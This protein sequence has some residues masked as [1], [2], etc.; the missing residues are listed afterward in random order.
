MS[1]TPEPHAQAPDPNPADALVADVLTVLAG[2]GAVRHVLQR[3]A[4]AVV[5][6]LD[7]AFARIW[8]LNQAEQVLELEASAGMYTHLDGQHSRIPVGA[9]KIGRIAEARRPHLTNDVLTDPE[10]SDPDWARR[11]G[12]VAFAGY[13]LLSGTRLLGVVAVLARHPLLS[14]SLEALAAASE[15]MAAVVERLRTQERLRAE[16]R[17]LT[18]LQR[19]G[20]AL[21]SAQ[22]DLHGVVQTVTDAATELSGAEFGAFFYN[23]MAANGE[24]YMLYTLSGA[25][26]DAFA[27]FGLPRNTPLFEPTFRGLRTLCLDDVGAD[28]RY[29][30]VP[31]HHGMPPGHLPVRSYLAV[32]VKGRDGTVLGGLFFGHAQPGVFTELSQ[33]AVEAIAGNAA[34]AIENARLY[35]R[36]HNVAVTLQRSL[37]PDRLPELDD[38]ALSAHYLPAAGEFEVGGDWYDAMVLPD[39]RLA[40]SVGDVMGHDLRAAAAMG[41]VR[42]ALRAYILEGWEPFG[43]GVLP[44]P[45]HERGG[46]GRVHHPRLRR[47]GSSAPL[48]SARAGRPP[49]ARAPPARRHRSAGRR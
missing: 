37:L 6:R 3:C 26:P 47:G 12:M 44:R 18:Q 2:S 8:T 30:R 28:P 27:D 35:G 20:L 13:P 21:S 33:L 15:A 39:G 42:S 11:E 46:P 36:E 23:A 14:G 19:V 24:A 5:C 31:P 29:G 4:E 40:V 25:S 34:V 48:P 17:V 41:Q 49:P 9:F 10:V 7:A 38:V 45:V 16:H 1:A 22:F 43:G 32:P